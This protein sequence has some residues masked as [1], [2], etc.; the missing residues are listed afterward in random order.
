V[1]EVRLEIPAR[2]EHLSLA[3]QVVAAAAAV[4]PRFDAERIDALRLAVSEAATNAVESHHD[5]GADERVIICCNLDEDRIEVEV[6]DRGG[7]FD[8]ADV[9]VV[10]DAATPERLAYEHGLG[11]PIMRQLTDEAEIRPTGRGTAVRLVVYRSAAAAARHAV[12]AGP[13]DDPAGATG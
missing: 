11:I 12:D 7:G 13:V 8:P 4:D 10:P 6:V 1:G 3:R 2:P 5:V 9:P